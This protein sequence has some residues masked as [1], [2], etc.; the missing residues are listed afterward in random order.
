MS[1]YSVSP[2][3]FGGA[4]A[5][6]PPRQYAPSRRYGLVYDRVIEQGRDAARHRDA[7]VRAGYPTRG[8]SNAAVLVATP[9]QFQTGPDR[10]T[11]GQGIYRHGVKRALDLTLLVLFSPFVVAVVMVLALLVMLD[12]GKPFYTQ[13]RIGQNGRIYR[14]WK[15]RSMVP[16]ADERLEDYLFANPDMR[17]EWEAKQKLMHDPRITRLGR[18]L[19]KSSMDELP[20]LLNVLKGEMSLVGPRPMMPSQQQMYDGDAYYELRPGITGLWQVSDRNESNFA[21]RSRFDTIYNR[22][23]SLKGDIKIL[24]ATVRVVLRGTGH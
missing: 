4:V 8:V 2:N 17:L 23:L 24:I 14:I 5:V 7:T 15:L 6:S 18:V 22:S 10:D 19:R 21:D 20:Q 11:Q 1:L 13:E 16:D 12:G 3:P 9:G